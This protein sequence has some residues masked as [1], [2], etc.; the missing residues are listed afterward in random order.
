[1]PL[2]IELH[3]TPR[4]PSDVSKQT[5]KQA[6][7]QATTMQAIP[8][9][10]KKPIPKST[11]ADKAKGAG[12]PSPATKQVGLSSYTSKSEQRRYKSGFSRIVKQ[13]KKKKE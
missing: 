7:K 8:D 3:V 6:S 11:L 1:M 4:Y 12:P 9:A 5:S 13:K 2:N 10:K